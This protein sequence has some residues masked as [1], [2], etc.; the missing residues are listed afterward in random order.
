LIILKIKIIQ[1]D[2]DDDETDI[3]SILMKEFEKHPVSYTMN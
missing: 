1:M 2:A 3:Y